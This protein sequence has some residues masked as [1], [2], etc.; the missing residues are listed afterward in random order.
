MSILCDL[1]EFVTQ[2]I[3]TGIQR[4]SFEIVSRWSGQAALV[5]VCL[6]ESGRF[7]RLP[8]FCFELMQAFFQEEDELRLQQIKTQIQEL[9]HHP[10]AALLKKLT[11][12]DCL[13]TP[14]VFFCPRRISFYQQLA[15]QKSIEIFL[16]VYDFLLWMQPEFFHEHAALATWPYLKLLRSIPHLAYISEWSRRIADEQIFRGRRPAGVTIPLGAD[17]LGAQV[18]RFDPASRSFVVVSTIE[19][20]KGH[21]QILRAFEPLWK[22]GHSI[23]LVFV[24]RKGWLSQAQLDRLERLDREQPLF[25][26]HANLRDPQ[27]RDVIL[28]SRAS[29]YLSQHEGFGL[30]P[31]ES[32]ALGKP[33]IVSPS[34]PSIDMIP[35]WGQIRIADVTPETIQVAVLELL[36]DD[37]AR[38]K[39]E[40]IASLDLLTWNAV[41]QS[42]ANWIEQTLQSGEKSSI[43][44]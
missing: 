25:T 10:Q 22:K 9:V 3:R 27:V 13:F 15:D 43:A 5:P 28:K 39:T 20:R 35:P 1:T 11:G 23:P 7:I 14:E 24:G 42:Y 18:P 6:A 12:F 17:G 34:I 4:V 21:L 26:W 29:I 30:P 8:A 36:D 19:P 44:A 2:P 38:A 41:S 31:V 40:E 32:L 33:V 37:R 16:I